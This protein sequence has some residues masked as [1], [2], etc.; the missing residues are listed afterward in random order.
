MAILSVWGEQLNEKKPL[1]E[2]PRMQLQRD[3]YTNLNG[4]WEYQITDPDKD[5]VPT[6]WKKIIVP[7][8]PGSKLS[9]TDEILLPGRT[10]WYRKQFAYQPVPKQTWLRFE[11]VDQCCTVYMNG[12]EVGS[13]EGGYCPFGFDVSGMIKYQN[14]LMLKCT[15]DSDTGRFA[16]GKQKVEHGG[17]WYTPSSGIWQTV[18]LEDI[19]E[20][21]V[22]DLKITPDCDA[23]SVIFD[24]AG[25][26]SQ[27]A[28]TIAAEGKIVHRGLT[29]DKH[30]EA[31]MPDARVWTPDD[32]FLYDVY[33][34]TEDDLIKSYFGMRKFSLGNDENGLV[35]F[36]LN[37]QPLFLS[38]LL[39]QGYT[40]DG[41]M[42]FPDDQAMVYE[43][44]KIKEMGFNML[45]KHV[46]VE[47][48][49]WYW[50]CDRL[51]ILV[52]QDM[53]NGGTY[54]FKDV[55]L[56]PTLGFHKSDENNPALGRT[57][58]LE[59]QIYYAELDAM[60]DELYNCT[61]L[62]AW[63]PFNEGWGQ[64][65]SLR[66]T[67]HIRRYD[68]TRLVDSASGWFDQGG[69]DFRSI[70]D[71]FFPY[72]TKPDKRG[73]AVLLSEF[74]GYSY[75]EWGH[76][77]AVKL[78]GYK[79]FTDKLKMDQA[80]S[81]LYEK[82]ILRNIPLGLAGC[83]YTQVSDIED[84]CNGLFTADRKIIKIDE[85]KMR[86]INERCRRKLTK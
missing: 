64:F 67:D 30:Y 10:L 3:S 45:R 70:H 33:I 29:N 80:V 8:S 41:G 50:H 76:C 7:F 54:S 31:P 59:K 73:R 19:G 40:I 43:L 81:A 14:S 6:L 79:K 74:G 38:G 28:I 2:Y 84:E 53:P 39:D 62:F 47:C 46:K 26:F 5:P 42:T 57:D 63:C 17:M 34:Q 66:V 58:Q 44:T 25:D 36:C 72:R 82:M 55:T 22:H 77:E 20:H 35:R 51:G 18:W 16:Y 52:M 56:L 27:A 12:I 48:R 49:R 11:A 85:K 65:S 60:M 78:Y 69:G 68:S 71:Y 21:A 1:Q 24:L 61:S 86:R 75:I 37:D 13:H 15:D 9:G 83:I 4:V 32:P 23:G